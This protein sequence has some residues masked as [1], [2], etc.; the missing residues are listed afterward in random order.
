VYFYRR[1]LR[2]EKRNEQ[3]EADIQ[4]RC[5]AERTDLASRI[6]QLEDRQHHASV[7]TLAK[8]TEALSF[9]T[10]ALERFCQKHGSGSYPIKEGA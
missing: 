10:R 4:A 5:D 2:N 7:E 1:D 9:N 3:R 8:V 6:R